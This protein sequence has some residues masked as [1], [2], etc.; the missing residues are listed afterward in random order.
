MS[1]LNLVEELF[2]GALEQPQSERE[3]WLAGKAPD[4]L[5]LEEVRSLLASR[6]K[7]SRITPIEASAPPAPDT[8]VLPTEHFGVYR[9]VGL[10]GRGGMGAVYL[11]ERTDGYFER[12]VA[13]KVMATHL[14]SEDF[15]R[16]FE[17]EG[18]LLAALDHPNIT[19]LLDGGVSPSGQSYLVLEYVKGERLDDYCDARRLAIRD[20]LRLFQQV[21]EAV[22]YAHRNLILHRDLKPS[23]ILVTGE[24][25]VKLLDFGTASLIAEDSSVTVTRAR[26][27]TP[28]YASPEQL[29]GERLGVAVDIFSLGVILYELLTG[30]WPFGNPDSLFSEMKRATGQALPAVPASAITPE[31]AALRS[32]DAGTLSRT[33]RGDLSAIVLKALEN[34]PGRRY[35]SVRQL[36]EDLERYSEGHPILAR[37]QTSLYR[38]R[39]FLRRRWLPVMAA[40]VFVIGLSVASVVALHQAQVAREEARKAQDE[41]RKSDRVTRFLRGMLSAGALAGGGDVT[42]LQMLNAAEP[43]IEKSWKDDPLSE[44]TLRAS[45]GATYVTLEQRDRAKLQLERALALFQ[46]LGRHVDAAD[47]LLVLGI[48]AQTIS[49]SAAAADSYRRAL[50]ALKL[51]GQEAPPRLVFRVKAYLAGVLMMNYH[52]TAEARALADEALALSARNPGFPPDLL[53]AAWQ[54]RGETMLEDG[55]FDEAEALFRQAIAANQYSFDAWAMLARS[56]F[57]KQNYS[58]AADLAHRDYQLAATYGQEDKA[59]AEVWWA[60]YRSETGEAAEA[61]A[62]IREALPI[63]RKYSRRG[64]LFAYYVQAGA[65]VLNN[66]GRFPEAERYARE[67]LDALRQDQIPETHPVT[68]AALEDLGAALCGLK[69]FREAVPALEK[70]AEIYRQLGPVY[71]HTAARVQAMLVRAQKP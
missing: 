17:T 10:L 30:V 71:T 20:R 54:H 53:V 44:A 21:C 55:R 40:T 8:P 62:Q 14:A 13:V 70:S 38:A 5:V 3:A 49:E 45:L 35:G 50:D 58:A 65:R 4:P 56:S 12:N 23:N 29:R 2:H 66:A 46:S 69:R 57:L 41:A 19:S 60:R 64:F 39:K 37:P 18:R 24:R 11:A 1:D 26:M 63:V 68:A 6:E 48:N 52:R 22:D 9:A 28:R 47:T 15:L 31:N 16:R 42:V 34:D 7:L 51:A 25:A 43:S 33:L 61:L 59:E 67:A 27:L 36:A 32:L